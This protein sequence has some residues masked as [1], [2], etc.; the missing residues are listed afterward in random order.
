MWYSCATRYGIKT[1]DK[2][3]KLKSRKNTIYIKDFLGL[4]LTKLAGWVGM[5]GLGR[6]ERVSNIPTHHP[7]HD[8]HSFSFFNPLTFLIFILSD[9]NGLMQIF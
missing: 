6:N 5:D 4:L 2:K 8:I 7:T 9:F 3:K 1:K